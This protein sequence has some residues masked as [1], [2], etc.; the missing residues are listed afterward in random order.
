M[1]DQDHSEALLTFF[2]ALAD[3]NRLRIIGILAQEAHT[4]EEIA[5]MLEVSV[6]TTSHH[7][8]R[9]AK[10]GLVSAIPEGHYYRYSLHTDT[11]QEMSQRIL[12]SEVLPKLHQQLSPLSYEEKVLKTFL[13]D[14]GQITAFPK[15]EKKFSIIVHHVFKAFEKGKIYSGQEVDEI[16]LGYSDDTASLRRALIE[17]RLMDRSKD[18]T[19]YWVMADAV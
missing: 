13:N 16:L 1:S 5:N 4:V 17:Y 11:L 14:Q 7:L 19:Q 8:S 2:K 15:A 18:G 3:Q 12:S 10:A 6:S 9:L